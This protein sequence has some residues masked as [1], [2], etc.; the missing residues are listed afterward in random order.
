MKFLFLAKVWI[1]VKP[2]VFFTQFKLYRKRRISWH[3]AAM[4]L[5]GAVRFSSRPLTSAHT[6]G[7]LEMVALYAQSSSG[8]PA[9]AL[10]G[11][12]K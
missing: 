1:K 2:Q 4:L 12:K 9:M 11:V 3:A 6:L 5:F 7:A 10:K 8:R